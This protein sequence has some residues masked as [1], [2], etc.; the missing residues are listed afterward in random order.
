MIAELQAENADLKLRAENA[1][2]ALRIDGLKA[3]K[4]EF[5]IEE[6]RSQWAKLPTAS[7]EVE[8]CAKKIWQNNEVAFMGRRNKANFMLVT[9][10]IISR[11]KTARE[12]QLEEAMKNIL[13]WASNKRNF[14]ETD[15]I[16]KSV[17]VDIA[18]AA[19]KGGE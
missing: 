16:D 5:E 11:H 14:S 18:N 10:N 1:E 7:P 4:A 13:E 15:A 2:A 19:L 17:V 9:G 12:K 8:K 3:E 6:A